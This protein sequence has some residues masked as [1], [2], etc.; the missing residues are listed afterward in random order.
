MYMYI[1]PAGDGVWHEP[2][3]QY[4]IRFDSI[5]ILTVDCYMDKVSN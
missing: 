3:R 5:S 4:S 1:W 2:T